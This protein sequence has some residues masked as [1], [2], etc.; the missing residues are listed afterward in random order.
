[1][2]FVL[3]T[4]IKTTLLLL[5][6]AM[7]NNE[8]LAFEVFHMHQN[9]NDIDLSIG[10]ISQEILSICVITK[11]TITPIKNDSQTIRTEDVFII[12]NSLSR[13]IIYFQVNSDITYRSFHHFVKNESKKIFFQAWLLEK[14]LDKLSVKTDSLRK[15][16]SMATNEQ[17]DAMTAYLLKMENRTIELNTEIPIL[18]ENARIEENK[19]WMSIS[20]NEIA[21]FK[22]KLK[23]FSDSIEQV[24][25]KI[26]EQTLPKNRIVSDTLYLE[27]EQSKSNASKPEI[28]S[29]IVYKIQIG[30]YK[31]KMPEPANKLIKK[32]SAIRKV[33]SYLDDKGVKVYTTGNLRNYNE[34][35]TLQSQVKQEGVKSPIIAA[36]L[37]GKRITVPEAKKL[38]NEL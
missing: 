29:E 19:Y 31:G 15:T 2:L 26:L 36:Y 9:R 11:D 5:L 25:Q 13:K 22:E 38:N 7:V 24:N 34:A 17:K 8:L 3:K 14:E 4:I 10:T 12:P 18:Y 28:G 30:A 23:Q 27:K 1:M 20:V 32:L 35:L 21:G 6:F 16:Y 33:E 37:K